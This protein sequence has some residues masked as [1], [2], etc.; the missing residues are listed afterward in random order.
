MRFSNLKMLQ[1]FRLLCGLFRNEKFI[2]AIKFG[3][4]PWHY[5][6]PNHRIFSEHN[7]LPA[8]LEEQIT[9]FTKVRSVEISLD[10]EQSKQYYDNG[11]FIFKNTELK[12][13]MSS[14]RLCK[15]LCVLHKT[16]LFKCFS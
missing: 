16:H 5:F 7:S 8:E 4:H 9:T 6:D 10:E 14:L 1:K 12:T 11:K 13:C 3:R 2:Y 15:V